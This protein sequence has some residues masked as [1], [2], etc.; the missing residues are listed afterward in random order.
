MKEMDPLPPS[1]KF[2]GEYNFLVTSSQ[3]LC[4]FLNLIYSFLVNFKGDQQG[5]QCFV[6]ALLNYIVKL[7]HAYQYIPIQV[8][9][10]L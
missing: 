6:L 10:N 9:V 3:P 4:I 5:G 7:I 1:L 8:E 2:K